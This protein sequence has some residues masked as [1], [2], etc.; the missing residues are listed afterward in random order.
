MCSENR[1]PPGRDRGDPVLGG[2]YVLD[3]S[4]DCFNTYKAFERISTRYK[5]AY[6]YQEACTGPLAVHVSKPASCAS[7]PQS[8]TSSSQL[9]L[10]AYGH[11]PGRS[12]C[13][14]PKEAIMSRPSQ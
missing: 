3:A 11:L 10:T 9:S 4:E 13:S 12:L 1:M 8:K 2:D 7:L 5:T 6:L 14:P